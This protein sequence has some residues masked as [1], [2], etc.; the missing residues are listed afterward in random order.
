MASPDRNAAGLRLRLERSLAVLPGTTMA[1]HLVAA[2]MSR[3]SKRSSNNVVVSTAVA[4]CA[5]DASV[6]PD[7]LVPDADPVC[8]VI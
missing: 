6:R 1:R 4:V 8:S 3:R 5:T 2:M 7:S